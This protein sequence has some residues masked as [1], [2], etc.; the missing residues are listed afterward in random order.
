MSEED[1][2][3][4]ETAIRKD[5]DFLASQNIMDY[6]LLLGIESKLQIN[7]ENSE[8]TVINAGR[9]ASV[10]STAELQRFK[11]HRFTSPDEMSTYH[12]SIIDFLQLWNCNKKSEQWL[13]TNFLRA[14]KKKLSAVEPKFYKARFQRFMRSQVFIQTL[15]VSRRVSTLNSSLKSSGLV[16]LN[17]SDSWT[18]TTSHQKDVVAHNSTPLVTIVEEG[19]HD[20]WFENQFDN[21]IKN[22]AVTD[23]NARVDLKASLIEEHDFFGGAIPA[24]NPTFAINNASQ[25]EVSRYSIQN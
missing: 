18:R 4:V 12:I 22:S 20:E 17:R 19:D 14:D 10:R 3:L 16:S 25:D 8:H 23:V 5:T 6:S 11:R 21:F 7:T 9:K 24:T 2:T 1:I 13:K 15:R